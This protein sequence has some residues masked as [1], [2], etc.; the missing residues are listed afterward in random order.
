MRGV[1]GTSV[2]GTLARMF[3]LF[4][5]SSVAFSLLLVALVVAGLRVLHA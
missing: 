3:V 1:Y 2:A 4:V 5:L